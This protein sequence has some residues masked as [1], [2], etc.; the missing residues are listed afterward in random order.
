MR[1]HMLSQPHTQLTDEYL[2]CAYTQKAVK[3]CRMLDKEG[4]KV[5]VYGSEDNETPAKMVT[6]ITKRQQAELGFAGP[7]DYLKNDFDQNSPLWKKFHQRV[8]NELP[9]N[10]RKGDI[11]GTFSGIADR[12]VKEAF[13]K[14]KFVELGIGYT[15]VFADFRVYESHAWYN[16]L[17]GSHY[18]ADLGKI[19]RASC[20]EIL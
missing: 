6:C 17:L 3:L 15:G 20:R 18:A 2:R 9:K 5:F 19:G 8:L 12:R 13:P 4:M 7:S 14:H 1:I 16:A 11:I 10:L